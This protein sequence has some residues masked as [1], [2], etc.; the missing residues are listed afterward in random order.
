M[1][2][3]LLITLLFNLI[4]VSCVGYSPVGTNPSDKSDSSE[5]SGKNS[6]V[7]TDTTQNNDTALIDTFTIHDWDSTWGVIDSSNV[8]SE[9]IGTWYYAYGDDGI[10]EESYS[11]A[12]ESYYIIEITEDSLFDYYYDEAEKRVYTASIS[13]ES[14]QTDIDDYYTQNGVLYFSEEGSGA[15]GIEKYRKYYGPVPPIEW[16][17]SDSDEIHSYPVLSIGQ[18]QRGTLS[19]ASPTQR[20]Q[21][22]CSA[23]EVY[24]ISVQM[25]EFDSKLALYNSDGTMIASND[26]YDIY[27]M[28]DDYYN[29]LWS[30]IEFDCYDSDTYYIEISSYGDEYGDYRLFLDDMVITRNSPQQ[31]NRKRIPFLRR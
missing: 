3:S 16:T 28:D 8:D 9:L 11:N 25:A 4:L 15:L 17:V 24:H 1:K 18:A 5:T 14:W 27:S 23:Y 31:E 6:D 12:G 19:E 20:Y 22:E 7:F 2:K 26:D 21:L 30:A 29:D 13:H 10:F